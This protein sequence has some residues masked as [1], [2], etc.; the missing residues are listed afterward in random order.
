MIEFLNKTVCFGYRNM[1]NYDRS[2]FLVLTLIKYETY[3]L[4][5]L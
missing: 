1:P 3:T 4:S 5:Y 2:E